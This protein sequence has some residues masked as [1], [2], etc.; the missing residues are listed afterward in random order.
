MHVGWAAVFDPPEDGP[1]PGFEELAEFIAARLSRAPR[2]RQM[3]RTVPFGINAPVWVDDPDFDLSRHLVRAEEGELSEVVDACMSE[4]L[5]RNR[6]LWQMWIGPLP[7]GRIALV[8][9]A[10]HCMVDGIAAVQLASLLLDPTPD[11]PSPEP[12]EWRPEPGPGRVE[13]LVRGAVEVARDQLTLASIPARVVASPQKVAEILGRGQ[14]ALEAVADSARPARIVAALNPEISSA[15]HLGYLSRPIDDLLFIKR[16]L[17]V[18][19]NDV[20]LAVATSGVR[21]FLGDR[22]DRPVDVKAMVPVNVRTDEEGDSLGNRISFMFIDLPCEE[23]DPIRRVRDL[24][25]ETDDRKRRHTPE[26]GDDVLGLLAFTPPPLQRLFAGLIAS[27]RAF[28]LVVSNIPG[29]R[30]DTYMRG[31]RLKEVYPVVPLADRHALSIGFTTVADRAGFGLYADR[32]A[33]PDVDHLAE[34]IDASIDEL[35]DL[36]ERPEPRKLVHA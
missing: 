16:R 5:P 25:A 18:T 14:R 24:H 12:D 28:N 2:Y 6:P 29:P 11:A 9:K 22:G 31:C 36:A 4:P 7:D 10:H 23:P 33:L 26:G 21:G 34:C 15:R 20:V 32:E 13:L 3:L 30:E 19:L 35:L 8:G 27:P 17:G 1:R